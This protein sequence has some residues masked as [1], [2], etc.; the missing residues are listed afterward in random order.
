VEDH[1]GN[2]AGA[3]LQPV[4]AL[5]LVPVYLLAIDEGAVFAAQIH[6]KKLAVFRNDASVLARHA[7]VG[8]HQVAVHLA[9]HRVRGVIQR[10]CL[11]IIALHEDRD[12]KRCSIY[13]MRRSRHVRWILLRPFCQPLTRP[14]S[15]LRWTRP[16]GGGKS[17]A[18]SRHGPLRAD[19]V[20]GGINCG[21]L[22]ALHPRTRVAKVRPYC[23]ST[24]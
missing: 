8:D 19:G 1:V 21:N 17:E 22:P 6:D 4:V 10:E 14:P 2:V 24:Q 9:A 18:A 12:G 15:I 11:L 3:E 5:Q 20:T 7:R 23:A 13:P 16:C